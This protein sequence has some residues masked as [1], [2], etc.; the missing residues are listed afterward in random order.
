MFIFPASTDELFVKSVEDHVW[1]LHSKIWHCRAKFYQGGDAVQ[2]HT[3][4]EDLFRQCPS[5]GDLVD[6]RDALE[7][8]AQIAFCEG[9]LSDAMDNLQTLV[10]IFDGQHSDGVLWCTVRKA[11]VAS[12]QGNCDLARELIQKASEP[13]Q[14]FSL[15]SARTFLHQS[16]GSACIELTAGK[17]D[18]A[19][20][21]F[22]T[23]IEACDMQGDLTFK[24]FSKRGLGEI[25]F[26]SNNFALATLHFEEARSLCTEMGVS[27]QH[28]YSCLLLDTL[29][30][31]FKGWVLFLRG[32]S[33][34]AN[35]TT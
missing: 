20:T 16:Y 18:R 26:A 19:E 32:M 14:F 12:K 10:G 27:P 17:C 4:L 33:P 34:F 13:F 8:L 15:R 7:G 29:P 6:H 21:Y 5:T 23:T 31:Q 11:V 24:A 30:D 9:R 3:R 2:M 35:N 28:L 25:A 22:T 1:G